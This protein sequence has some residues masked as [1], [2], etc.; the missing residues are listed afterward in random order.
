MVAG[1]LALGLPAGWL[2]S[3]L[4]RPP[5]A[6]GDLYVVEIDGW[7]NRDFPL[8]PHIDV[9]PELSRGEWVVLLY[10]H[11][12]TK[13]QEALDQY[14]HELSVA[15]P[16]SC[17]FA[18]VEIPPWAPTERPTV[19]E[20]VA[21]RLDASHDWFIEAPLHLLL[22]DGRVREVSREVL[23]VASTDRHANAAIAAMG[24]KGSNK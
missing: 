18:F 1:C 2:A 20:C 14:E 11:D 17:R 9:G 16:L 22:S 13:C 5:A 23:S 10:H 7:L 21:G 15:N 19:G 6:T 12:C 3:G 4:H 8:L 24:M